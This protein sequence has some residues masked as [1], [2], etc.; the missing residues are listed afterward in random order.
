VEYIKPIKLQISEKL[1]HDEAYRK[2]F[3]RANA[4]DGIALQIRD[5]RKRRKLNQIALASECGMKQSA[6]SR[7][8]QAEYSAWTFNTLWRVAEAL[9]ARLIVTFQP[10]EEAINEFE[11][12]EREATKGSRKAGN[13]NPE[14]VAWPVY[15]VRGTQKIA[16]DS[17]PRMFVPKSQ[18]SSEL[19]V[20]KSHNTMTTG[21]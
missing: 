17:T 5:L 13:T 18:R 21:K 8:E 15:E 10:I 14:R 9:K 20:P 12:A 19:I 2:A 6:V 3:F 1:K 11:T 7:I 16:G 4:T